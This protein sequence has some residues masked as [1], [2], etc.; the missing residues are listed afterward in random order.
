MGSFMELE[1]RAKK[2]K[3]AAA[4][5]ADLCDVDS[6]VGTTAAEVADRH[7]SLLTKTAMNRDASDEMKGFAAASVAG[8]D[9]SL[10]ELME[11]Q[12]NTIGILYR[13]MNRDASDEMKG[14]AAASVAGASTTSTACEAAPRMQRGS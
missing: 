11:A 5:V 6:V 12:H 3:R 1:Q 8:G 10:R 13:L 7:A 4:G 14:F 2:E 9:S